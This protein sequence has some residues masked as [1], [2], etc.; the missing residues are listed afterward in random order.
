LQTL[1]RIRTKLQSEDDSLQMAAIDQYNLDFPETSV[2]QNIDTL[3]S[4]V[5]ERI[6]TLIANSK[7]VAKT[8]MD[9]TGQF[10]RISFQIADIGSKEMHNVEKDVASIVDSLLN[11]NED[12]L[13]YYK[14]A[15]LAAGNLEEKTNIARSF[16]SNKT[17]REG[18]GDIKWKLESQMSESDSS[19]S[20]KFY[21]DTTLIYD[22]LES[23]NFTTA[24]NQYIDEAIYGY[25]LT[26]TSVV[27]ARETTFLVQNLIVSL[28]IAVI[29]IAVLMALLFSSIKMVL[30]SLLPNFIPLLT[31][32]G[33]MGLFG[34]PIKPSTALVF[35]VAFGI[36]I[37]DTIHYLAKYRQELKH[38][39]WNIKGSVLKALR[40]T[41]VSMI[42]TS[43]VLFFGFCVFATSDFG[44]TVALGVLVS[45]TLMVAM[46]SNLVVLPSLLLW[47]DKAITNKAFKEPLLELID[48][49]EDIEL[50][51]LEIE[52][53]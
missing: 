27:F 45:V 44:G 53:K 43:I 22:L 25:S 47:L 5:E 6:E 51:D 23:E 2:I 42:Y 34:I 8:F 40:E 28:A 39:S 1:K 30:V 20:H 4:V 35:S 31:T 46:L 3:T 21:E 49:E 7:G 18:M 33:I 38:Q 14:D 9:S 12:S 16:F 37:D 29:M 24:L 41:G 26:G 10:T 13:I 32:A 15:L 48:E 36:S 52:K 11:P 17:L 50:D 19:L